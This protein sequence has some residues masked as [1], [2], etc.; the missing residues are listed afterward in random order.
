MKWKRKNK[1]D[2]LH[3]GNDNCARVRKDADGIVRLTLCLNKNWQPASVHDTIAAAKSAGEA[4][5]SA[6]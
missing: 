1:A 6:L 4:K 2:Y 5:L 3:T